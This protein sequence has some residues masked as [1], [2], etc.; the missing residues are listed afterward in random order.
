MKDNRIELADVVRRFKDRYVHEF[1]SVMMT[2]RPSTCRSFHDS[3]E[4]R[5][6]EARSCRPRGR[7]HPCCAFSGQKTASNQN[8]A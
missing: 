3:G 8:R 6:F 7:L 1:G 5:I 2:A 4:D